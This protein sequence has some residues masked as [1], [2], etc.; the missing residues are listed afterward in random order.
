MSAI[1]VA[2][3]AAGVGHRPPVVPR[4]RQRVEVARVLALA[5]LIDIGVIFIVLAPI[6]LLS[7]CR[8]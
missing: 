2:K 1:R 8:S 3:D 6:L 5:L 4:W 7:W